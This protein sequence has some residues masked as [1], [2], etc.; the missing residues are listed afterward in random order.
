MC[1]VASAMCISFIARLL[2]QP[3]GLAVTEMFVPTF[4]S[5]ELDMSYVTQAVCCPLSLLN[6]RSVYVRFMAD[7]V[8]VGRF[9]SEYFRWIV[10]I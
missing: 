4:G 9:L 7:K 3:P 8:I 6:V 1:S 5:R 2:G 10:F